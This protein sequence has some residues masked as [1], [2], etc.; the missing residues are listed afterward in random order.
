MRLI[1]L[2]LT[3]VKALLCQS[4]VFL[5]KI[6]SG[7]Y[8]RSLVLIVGVPAISE[9]L[10]VILSKGGTAP[11][12]GNTYN[13]ICSNTRKPDEI[14]IGSITPPAASVNSSTA[15]FLNTLLTQT[16]E[17]GGMALRFAVTH[18]D[19]YCEAYSIPHS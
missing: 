9:S 14:A 4:F 2:G 10:V 13:N 6:F 18:I 11:C 8:I 16:E 3:T 17:G 1:L 7:S 15:L 12:V 19:T 5:I